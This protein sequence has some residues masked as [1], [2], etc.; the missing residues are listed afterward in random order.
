[1]IK[2]MQYTAASELNA[3]F[4]NS[5]VTVFLSDLLLSA[6]LCDCRTTVNLPLHGVKDDFIRFIQDVRAI[7]V[8]SGEQI[9]T[10]QYIKSI[11]SF[12][13]AYLFT[14]NVCIVQTYRLQ[15]IIPVCVASLVCVCTAALWSPW[16]RKALRQR[17]ESLYAVTGE[18][19]QALCSTEQ[20]RGLTLSIPHSPIH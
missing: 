6:Q 18:G 19:N 11:W 14:S 7:K 8:F 16:P 20:G 15:C 1:M 13:P 4:L 2:N 5:C 17:A 9:H 10:V 12:P 3:Q